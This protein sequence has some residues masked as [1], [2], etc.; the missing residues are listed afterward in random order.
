MASS[1]ICELSLFDFSEII[2]Q[3]HPSEGDVPDDGM[4][5]VESDEAP[6]FS[7]RHR[8]HGIELYTHVRLED[9]LYPI[10]WE[11]FVPS[12]GISKFSVVA[13]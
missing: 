4:S 9:V 6:L 3:Q 8:S 10:G 11:V 5:D 2:Y 7:C 12:V 13:V 1:N